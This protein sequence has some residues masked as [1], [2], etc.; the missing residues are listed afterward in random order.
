MKKILKVL[1]V[2]GLAAVF[3]LSLIACGRSPINVTVD[4]NNVARWKPV[5]GAAAYHVMYVIDEDGTPALV[6][7]KEIEDT[8]LQLFPGVALHIEAKYE[9][10]TYG[11]ITITEYT[12]GEFDYKNL[13]LLLASNSAKPYI[14][15]QFDIDY[16]A[17][18]IWD[19]IEGIDINS[20]KHEDDGSVTF[21]SMGPDGSTVRFLGYDIDVYED[22]IVFHK[23]GRM[24]SM[25][26]IGRIVSIDPL[27]SDGGSENDYMSVFG[28]F[29]T[30]KDPHPKS[31]E[32][33]IYTSGHSCDTLI[34]SERS[35]SRAYDFLTTQPN[36]VG[37][38]II[39]LSYD[40]RGYENIHDC[41]LSELSV[42]YLPDD[43]C[44]G[45]KE[46]LLNDENYGFVMEGEKYNKAKEG[47]YNPSKMILDF[48]LYAIPDIIGEKNPRSFE[49]LKKADPGYIAAFVSD[50]PSSYTIGD[51]KDKN[52]KVLDKDNAKYEEGMALSVNLGNDTFDVTYSLS[53]EFKGAKTM[54]DLVPYAFPEALGDLNVLVVPIAWQDEVSNATDK[55]YEEL[56]QEFGR[57]I[58][59]NGKI[60]DHSGQ[61]E[62]RFSLSEYFD[63]ASYGKLKVNSFMTDWYIAPHD[64]SEY[65][66][67]DIDI[68]FENEVMDWFYANY[69][70]MDMSKFD[71][72][73]N[74]YIDSAV[75][76]NIGDMSDADGYA[77]ISFEGGILRRET[78]GKEYAQTP[79][80]P[81]INCVVNMN[82]VHF[83]DNTLIH[84]LSH[85]FGLIDYYDVT[86]SG[87]NAV[88]GYDMQSGN[89]GDWNVYSKYSVG[90]I[91]P[92]VVKDLNPG[93]SKEITISSFADTG[94]AIVIP[95]AGSSTE[96]PFGEYIALELFTGTGAD[97][98][99]A[100]E[101]GLGNFEGVRIYHVDATMESHDYVPDDYPDM[102]PVTVGTIH[103][104]NDYKENGRYNLEVIQAG[105]INT[106]TDLD[107]NIRNID[108]SDFFKAGDTF[109]LDKYSAF[110][111]EGKLDFDEDFGYRIDIVSITGTGE[112]AKAVIK[113][114]RE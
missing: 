54:H 45:F 24:V 65:R 18:K 68:N 87:A 86:Y 30:Y 27:I 1:I 71:R 44:T 70:D 35:L 79:D 63:I 59:K 53:P 102:E 55:K 52:G 88:G 97:K 14:T 9:D 114:T 76:V 4:E 74:G 99:D 95:A 40:P 72:D 112:N 69:P 106:F 46:I 91:D 11:P 83:S 103:Y 16:D 31:L 85:G 92:V 62:N 42:L 75:F 39:P 100:S 94:D 32:H 37:F 111:D 104:A 23:S 98:Y 81:K 7:E 49:E 78:Y 43:E 10:G 105:A 58:D 56:Q 96:T 21:E 13:D 64:F 109:T 101:F 22:S 84:E 6:A 36:F 50:V 51:L 90:W 20:V 73:Q 34:L 28:G 80:R 12:E 38:G 89:D 33:M 29:D 47:R 93:E 110:F 3:S 26:S 57:V 107:K 19:C 82:S 2:I 17:L 67:M 108:Q 48:T 66:M 61:L 15:E 77:I 8:S 5:K 41:T 25:D 60:T 113:I